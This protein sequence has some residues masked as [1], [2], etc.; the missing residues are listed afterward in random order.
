MKSS[1][2]KDAD[3]KDGK[4][5]VTLASGA[6]YEYPNVAPDLY[7]KFAATF[8]VDESTGRFYGQHIRNLKSKKL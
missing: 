1:L 5:T 3:Y 2:I 7:E 8:E 6:R 4:L